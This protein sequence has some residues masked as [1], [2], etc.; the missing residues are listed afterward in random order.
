MTRHAF[1]LGLAALT[2]LALHAVLLL[3]IG[4]LVA[5]EPDDERAPSPFAA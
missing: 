2:A 1:R 3:L 4:L 5:P